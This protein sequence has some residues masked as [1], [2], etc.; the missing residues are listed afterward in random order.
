MIKKVLGVL[1]LL[2]PFLLSSSSILA[3]ESADV[4]ITVTA[5]PSFVVIGGAILGV[6]AFVFIFYADH[7]MGGRK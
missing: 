6:I 4:D 3:A 2:L 1:A 5:S 7:I